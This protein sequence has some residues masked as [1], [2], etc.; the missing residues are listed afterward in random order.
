MFNRDVME[1]TR[2]VKQ[3]F[4]SL[5]KAEDATLQLVMPSYYLLTMKMAPAVRD[6]VMTRTFKD[7]LR[8]YLDSTFWTSINAL[9]WM[10]TFLDPSFKQL[11]FIPENNASDAR[12]KRNLQSDL[13]TWMTEEL[14]VVTERLN[15]CVVDAEQDRL[16]YSFMLHSC[17]HDIF[18]VITHKCCLWL[19]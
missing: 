19:L 2:S 3:V 11:V 7:N 15:A 6:S 14:N 5:E 13:D 8:K 4:E 12:F 17:L 10:A 16:E 18:L 1:I 9:H